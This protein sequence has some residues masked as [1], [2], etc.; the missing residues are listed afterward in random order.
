MASGALPRGNR[1]RAFPLRALRV[2]MAG[3]KGGQAM[4]LI[5]STLFLVLVFLL[6]A[7]GWS[8]NPP[9]AQGNPEI[10][11]PNASL[12]AGQMVVRVRST[13]GLM[14][15]VPASVR[16]FSNFNTFQKT[17]GTIDNAQAVFEGVPVGEYVVEVRAP[18][19]A[20]ANEEAALWLPNST[21]YV[22]V[23]LRL[24]SAPGNTAAPSGPPLLAP[25][26]KKEL[27]EV[28]A[29][30]RAN[31]LKKA[32]QHLDKVRKLA[33][34]HPDVA[35]LEGILFL[36]QHD[37]AQARVFL[38]RAVN[39]Y[40]EHAAA[41]SALGTLL[42][43]QNDC[44]AAMAALEKAVQLL[45]QSWEPHRI[46][47]LCH[48]RAASLQK[49]RA[50]TERAIETAG[51]RAPELRLLRARVF[52]AGKEFEKARQELAAFRSQNP[53]HPALA[54]ADRLLAALNA[55][56]TPKRTSPASETPPPVAKLSN[57]ALQS[58]AKLA[59]APEAA[60]AASGLLPEA[61]LATPLPELTRSG[62]R[63]WA[64]P[65]LADA[66]PVFSKAASC[67][68]DAVFAGTQRR[69]V[70]LTANLERITASERIEYAELDE[71]GMR[72]SIEVVQY[73]YLVSIIEVRPGILSV[74]ESRRP[75]K[76]IVESPRM[77][78]RGLVALALV[79]HPYYAADFEMRC[80]GLTE[81]KGQPTWSVFFQQRSDRPSR[82]RTYATGH[83]QVPVPLKG[84]AWITAGSFQVLRM[85]TELASPVEAL[86]LEAEHLVVEYKSVEFKSRNT[87]VWLPSNA[88]FYGHFKGRRY[89]HEH[90]F[91]DYMI[92]AVDLAHT[93]GDPKQP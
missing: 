60:T 77:T 73:D 52:L 67:S 20:V 22:Y 41:Q 36:Q 56:L 43:Q 85:E 75:V 51:D 32:R 84:R 14:L 40:P 37:A 2:A 30:L 33:P 17:S 1:S 71:D 61:L 25:K 6:A 45:P 18:G 26:A 35:Y 7:P 92:F 11:L 50:H 70:E 13:G 93:E 19:F 47:A 31:D 66:Q 15:Q 5:Q 62:P 53:A 63:R 16:I 81:W 69:A 78:S 55:E 8:Q 68:L 82:I 91:R 21:T 3:T 46:L 58:N 54:E 48:L 12:G 57:P 4:R 86:R 39:I 42:F 72:R 38:E 90:R 27:E 9:R 29:A 34:G 79:F 88:Q 89:F 87:R 28:A 64:P 59:A 74:E 44:A 23:D 24:E 10:G 83:G 76:R 49:A 80:E 65:S